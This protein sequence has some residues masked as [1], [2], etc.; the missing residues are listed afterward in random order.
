MRGGTGETAAVLEIWGR[1]SLLKEIHV[2]KALHGGVYNDGWFGAGAAWSPDETRLA[3]VAEVRR[4]T[5]VWESAKE[6]HGI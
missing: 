6:A 2:P 3:Y 4:G 1:G 5:H